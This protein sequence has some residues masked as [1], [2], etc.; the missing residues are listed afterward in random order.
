M[1]AN[2]KEI[3]RLKRNLRS[4]YRRWL[5][6]TDH[7]DCGNTLARYISGRAN[8]AAIDVN[9]TLDELAKLDPG[10]PKTRLPG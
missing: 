3:A 6:A 4:A 1:Q 2:E 10:T 7:L 5:D 9:N 8:R